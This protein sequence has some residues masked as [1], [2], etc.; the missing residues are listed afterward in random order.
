[1]LRYRE[2]DHHGFAANGASSAIVQH[3]KFSAP[4]HHFS[5]ADD[6]YCRSMVGRTFVDERWRSELPADECDAILKNDRIG[7]LLQ[8]LGYRLTPRRLERADS[9]G[10]SFARRILSL[11]RRMRGSVRPS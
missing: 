10:F 5:T 7:S 9:H 3:H 11:G 8:E 2:V 6:G 1:M 4:P